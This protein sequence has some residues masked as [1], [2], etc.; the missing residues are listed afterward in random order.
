M[1][2]IHSAM[3]PFKD[4]YIM[5]EIDFQAEEL[6]LYSYDTNLDSSTCW[7]DQSMN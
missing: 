7:G 6:S 1:N 5:N 3:F 4:K 2:Q